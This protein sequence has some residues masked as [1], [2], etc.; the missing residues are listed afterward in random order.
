MCLAGSDL[1]THFSTRA[2][3][4]QAVE[5]VSFRVM[6]GETLGMVGESG[7]GKTITCLSMCPF[8][9]RCPYVMPECRQD[10]PAV[11]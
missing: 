2:G 10:G 5:G 9:P 7:S 3:R 4:V 8:H 1:S 11:T 6:P